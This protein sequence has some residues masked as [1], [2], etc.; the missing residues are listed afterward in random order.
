MVPDDD[1]VF[2]HIFPAGAKTLSET[3]NQI[4]VC[5][6]VM[7]TAPT[8]AFEF[9]PKLN[10]TT[11]LNHTYLNPRYTR[12][13]SRVRSVFYCSKFPVRLVWLALSSHYVRTPC[14]T[15]VDR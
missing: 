12:G 11:P 4:A 14:V 2:L 15:V 5:T 10:L 9:A 1:I 8:P 3:T 7:H 6:S 13:W